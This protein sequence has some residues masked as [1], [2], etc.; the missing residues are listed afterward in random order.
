MPFHARP[1]RAASTR[2]GGGADA[3]RNETEVFLLRFRSKTGRPGF[4]A[5]VLGSCA[6]AAALFASST[7]AAAGTTT[8]T[9]KESE[10]G[11][12]FAFIDNPPKTKQTH[13][14]PV[15]I[16]AGDEFV[17]KNPLESGGKTIGNLQAFCIATRTVKGFGKAEFLCNGT[18]TIAG[19]GTLTG[20]AINKGGRTEGAITGGTGSYAGA[21]GTVVSKPGKGATTITLLE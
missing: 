18:F 6:I 21:R 19:K 15:T 7:A 4:V 16:S 11:G 3:H 14:G 13:N 10:K 17:L 5:A 12:S 9:F 8:L 1:P 20:Q 2:L